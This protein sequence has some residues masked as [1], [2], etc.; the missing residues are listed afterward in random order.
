MTPEQ[1]DLVQSTAAALRADLTSVAAGFYERL[2]TDRP[3]LEPLFSTDPADQQRKFADQLDEILRSLH[4]LP[5]FAAGARQLGVRHTGYGVT[6]RHY[7]WVG[8][9]LVAAVTERLGDAA[10]PD[11]VE[12]WTLAYNL[13]AEIMQQGAADAA[14]AGRPGAPR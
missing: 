8:E 12:A 3:E 6:A 4:D 5:D 10:T 14:P 9:A 11:V 2:F 7:R 13:L 1:I